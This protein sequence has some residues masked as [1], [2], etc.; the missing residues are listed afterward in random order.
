MRV[1]TALL[2]ALMLSSCGSPKPGSK[3]DLILQ[4]IQMGQLGRFEAEERIVRLDRSYWPV[5]EKESESSVRS[6]AERL[7][8]LS[9]IGRL[10]TDNADAILARAQSST[11]ENARLGAAL[12]YS[13]GTVTDFEAALKRASADDS[14]AVRFVAF[15][16]AS[17]INSVWS[18]RLVKDR[19]AE[20]QDPS[21][22]AYM[23][24]VVSKIYGDRALFDFSRMAKRAN[25][26]EVQ[27]AL[28]GA[29]RRGSENGVPSLRVLRE[30]KYPNVRRAAAEAIQYLQAA[31][32]KP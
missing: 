22:L 9:V 27:M 20:E 8:L 23:V 11:N 12:G 29:F 18:E 30:S 1:A 13:H 4:G 10:G 32:E 14:A 19:L 28:V 31:V 5:L 21:L 6:P 17:G 25:H 26:Q 16:G 15:T 2:I 3:L 7:A 24:T